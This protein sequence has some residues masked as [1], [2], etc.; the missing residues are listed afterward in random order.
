MSK[1]INSEEIARLAGVSRSTVSRVINGYSNVPEQTRKKVM[2]VIEQVGYYPSFS[3]QVMAGMHTHTL[4]FICVAPGTIAGDIQYSSYFAHVIE[5]AAKCGY[6]VLSCVVKNLTS[7][8]NIRWV[9]RL[10]FEERI[11]AGIFIGIDNDSSLLEELIAKGKIVGIFDH[12]HPDCHEPNRISV[13]Y[14]LNTGEKVI[15]YLY[16]LGHRKIALISGNPNR[17]SLLNRHESF[18]RGLL[19]HGIEPRREWTYFF[20]GGELDGGYNE[21]ID[22]I[23]NCSEL[24]TAICPYND[25]AAF[26]VYRALED[27]GLQ[28]PNDISVIGIDGHEKAN[29]VTPHLTSFAFPR[30]D[31]FYS[32]VERVIAVVEGQDNVPTTAFFCSQL[33]ER[34][35]C[36]R[37]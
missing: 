36:K 22:M 18:I 24:P 17:F 35:S 26:E 9:R 34:E 21:T 29:I 3:S 15:D 11:D 6:F 25:T 32:L 37:I 31:I 12:F 2:D 7:E 20:Y 30:K 16:E 19:K 8:E 1:K 23:K 13:N 4:G 10:F 5:C 14:E 27:L 28:I 33:I